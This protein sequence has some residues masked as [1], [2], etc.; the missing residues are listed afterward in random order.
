M[1]NVFTGYAK[2]GKVTEA[3]AIDHEDTAVK[4]DSGRLG[5]GLIFQNK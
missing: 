3:E 2:F 1:L 5:M 4:I